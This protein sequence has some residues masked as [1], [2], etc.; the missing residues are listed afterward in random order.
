MKTKI[1]GIF[2]CMLMLATAV[3]AVTYVKNS[4]INAM[5]PSHPLTS[6]A[7]NWTE[8]QKLLAAD[9]ASDDSFGYSVALESDTILIGAPEGPNDPG[10][11]YV[12]TRT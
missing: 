12:F 9:G 7:G 5:A 8:K 2:V 1:V 11:V 3:P 10:S 6:M 4:A